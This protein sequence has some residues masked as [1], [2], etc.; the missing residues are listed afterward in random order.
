MRGIDFEVVWRDQDVTEYRVRCSNGFFSGDVNVYANDGDLLKAADLLSGFP[1]DAKDS[2]SFELGTFE[3]DSAGG[4]IQADFQCIDSVGHAIACVQLRGDGC[5][6]MGEAQSVCL[7]IPVV[8]GSIDSFVSQAR[9]TR[10]ESSAKAHL[11]MADHTAG[12]VRRWL[13]AGRR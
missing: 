1:R 5:R 9:S 3:S 2:R 6:R 11:Q 10:N 13:E 12:W 8:A 7:Q 4:G